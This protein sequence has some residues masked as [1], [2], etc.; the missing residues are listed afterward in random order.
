VREFAL[1]AFS[2]I[3]ALVTGMDWMGKPLRLVQV[4][5]LVALGMAAGVALARAAPAA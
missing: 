4:L 2:I 1:A 5:T 3:I